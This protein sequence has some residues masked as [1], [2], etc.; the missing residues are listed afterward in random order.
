MPTKQQVLEQPA[1]AYRSMQLARF[2]YS[3]PTNKQN[4]GALMRW[5]QER[6]LNLNALKDKRIEIPCGQRYKGQTEPTTCRPSIRINERTPKPLA[7]ELTNKQIEKAIAIK[8]LK[9][10]IIWSKL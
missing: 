6:W 5:T 3:R 2:G 7:S 10:R 8:K 1:S 4:D 9:K